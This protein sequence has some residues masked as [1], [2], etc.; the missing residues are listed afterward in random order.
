MKRQN[1]KYQKDIVIEIMLYLMKPEIRKVGAFVN[2]GLGKTFIG[3]DVASLYLKEG[4]RVV[5]SAYALKE[6]KETWLNKILDFKLISPADLQVIVPA[7]DISKYKGK[8]K[9]VLFTTQENL[10]EER[11]VI[12][13]IPQSVTKLKYPVDLFIIDEIHEYYEVNTLEG[14]GRLK[15]I[16]KEASHSNTKILGLT[17]TGFEMVEEGEFSKDNSDVAYVIRDLSFALDQKAILPVTIS[18]EYFNFPLEENCY[19][20]SGDLKGSGVKKLSSRLKLNSVGKK[21]LKSKVSKSLQLDFILDKVEGS[22]KTL[23][24]VPRGEDLNT[25]ICSYINRYMRN[26]LNI[27]NSCVMKTSKQKSPLNDQVEKEFRNNPSVKFMVVVDMCGTGWDFENLDNVIDLTFTKNIKLVIQRMSRPCRLSAGKSPHY[28]FCTDQ[29]K[30]FWKVPVFLMKCINLTTKDGI[31]NPNEARKE[32][33]YPEDLINQV[34]T[35]EGRNGSIDLG[36]IRQYFKDK[37]PKVGS[38]GTEIMDIEAFLK[39]EKGSRYPWHDYVMQ[40]FLNK[41]KRTLKKLEE[42]VPE[43]QVAANK[44]PQESDKFMNLV[45]AKLGREDI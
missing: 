15:K 30:E 37:N 9:D 8:Y 23:V 10:V 36:D 32:I 41:D 16:I 29:T 19:K 27:E 17:G 25:S 6:I 34:E 40:K 14:D 13:I 33:I 5:I 45:K 21:V 3:A 4:K 22:N 24:I 39:K 43:L 38:R 44:I 18:M 35:L 26:K 31:L 2:C 7:Y 42:L 11:R 12:I 28:F 20:K 1:R